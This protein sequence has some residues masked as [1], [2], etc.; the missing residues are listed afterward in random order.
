MAGKKR[1]ATAPRARSGFVTEDQ[2][3]TVR[4]RVSREHAEALATRWGLTVENAVRRAVKEAVE[5]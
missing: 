2:R 5:R 3:H 1:G 4:V